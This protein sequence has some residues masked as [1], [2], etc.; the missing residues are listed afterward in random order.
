MAAFAILLSNRKYGLLHPRYFENRPLESGYPTKYSLGPAFRR[1]VFV[2]QMITEKC[3]VNMFL[4]EN[5]K[6][7]KIHKAIRCSMH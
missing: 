7:F 3:I 1:K 4:S 2:Y 5:F 6:Q